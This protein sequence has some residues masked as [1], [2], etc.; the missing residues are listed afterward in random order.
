MQVIQSD[1][2]FCPVFK[3]IMFPL[4]SYTSDSVSLHLVFFCNDMDWGAVLPNRMPVVL[5]IQKSSSFLY[6]AFYLGTHSLIE[7]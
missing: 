5:S 6:Y 2:Q 4:G 1:K 7:S 3:H